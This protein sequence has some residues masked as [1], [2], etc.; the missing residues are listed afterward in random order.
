MLTE[1]QCVPAHSAGRVQPSSRVCLVTAAARDQNMS[2]RKKTKK[3]IHQTLQLFIFSL[4]TYL[5]PKNSPSRR[6]CPSHTHSQTK[7]HSQTHTQHTL[8]QTSQWLNYSADTQRT[9]KRK[10]KEE[11]RLKREGS[12]GKKNNNALFIHLSVLNPAYFNIPITMQNT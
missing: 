11:Y 6:H 8:I 4:S 7:I 5:K 9:I 2:M 12:E 3:S 10:R 1:Q